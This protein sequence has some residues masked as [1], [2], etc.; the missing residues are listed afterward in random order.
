M[1]SSLSLAFVETRTASMEKSLK[2]TVAEH[3]QEI[4]HRN[5]AGLG[6]IPFITLVSTSMRCYAAKCNKGLTHTLSL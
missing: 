6:G 5:A 2:V 4:R 1:P 3:A